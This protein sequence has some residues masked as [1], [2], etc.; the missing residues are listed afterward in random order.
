MFLSCPIQ[1]VWITYPFLE[2]QLKERNKKIEAQDT[3]EFTA[4]VLSKRKGLT[5]SLLF[6]LT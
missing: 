5:S 1:A 6:F 2:P 4:F 3:W